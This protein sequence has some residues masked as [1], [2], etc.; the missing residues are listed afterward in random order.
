LI[1]EEKVFCKKVVF[2]VKVFRKIRKKVH[3]CNFWVMKKLKCW[4]F[5][6]YFQLKISKES[7]IYFSIFSIQSFLSTLLLTFHIPVY[8][9]IYQFIYM[10]Q[11]QVPS[12]LFQTFHINLKNLHV[13]ILKYRSKT[14]FFWFLKG[15]GGEV[16]LKGWEAKPTSKKKWFLFFWKISSSDKVVWLQSIP[17]LFFFGTLILKII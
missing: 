9:F 1:F 8:L 7:K 15:L 2:S 12:S 4:P 10:F 11:I 3:F 14:C 16:H 6:K 17:K 13:S 5:W